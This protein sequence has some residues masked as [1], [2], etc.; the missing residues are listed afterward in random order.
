M[1][2]EDKHV[3][4]RVLDQGAE[5]LNKGLDGRGCPVLVGG[6]EGKGKMVLVGKENLESPPVDRAVSS[7]D[8]ITPH[9]GAA[10]THEK[11]TVMGI[12]APSTALYPMM[13]NFT[14][15]VG[16]SGGGGSGGEVEFCL[17]WAGC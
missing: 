10:W 9:V 4:S 8:Q 5:V 1:P 7:E 2:V 12:R 6:R 16:I 17:G 13:G 14:G 3:I 15:N 11:S